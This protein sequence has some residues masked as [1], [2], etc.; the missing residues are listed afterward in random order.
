MT[1]ILTYTLALLGLYLV[2][3]GCD[4]LINLTGCDY[5]WSIYIRMDNH[6]NCCYS[7]NDKQRR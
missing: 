2:L 7:T 6:T 1:E 4:V 3:L 5:D